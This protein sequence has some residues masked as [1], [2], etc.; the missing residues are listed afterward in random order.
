MTTEYQVVFKTTLP[1]SEF[2]VP[3]TEIQLPGGSTTKDMTQVLMELFEDASA[4]KNRKFNFMVDN[5]FLSSTLHDL[6][7]TKL[8]KSNE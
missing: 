6:L 1:G 3:E 8:N 4:V 2:E 7:S 5:T